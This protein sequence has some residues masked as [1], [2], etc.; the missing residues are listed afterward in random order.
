MGEKG[1]KVFS[2]DGA[3]RYVPP[4]REPRGAR[5]C[6][7]L[8]GSRFFLAAFARASLP[9][10]LSFL[11]PLN[12]DNKSLAVIQWINAPRDKAVSLFRIRC[13]ASRPT[14]KAIIF[15]AFAAGLLRAA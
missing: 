10:R 2:A 12:E 4:K 3:A 7:G 5:I 13:G 6:S 15:P 9:L 14:P 11:S 8:L 1:F